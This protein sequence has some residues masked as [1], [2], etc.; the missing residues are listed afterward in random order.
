MEDEVLADIADVK[1]ILRGLGFLK[2]APAI[3]YSHTMVQNG[4]YLDAPASGCWYPRK[5]PGDQI[6]KGEL[7]GE[8]RNIF[9][10]PLCRIH[11]ETDGVVL[12]Q[13]VSLGIETGAPMIAYGELE[14][15]V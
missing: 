7:L 5:K 11:A 2:D 15:E 14:K 10:E 12:Y 13:T 6:Q 8:I 3:S 9:S 4:R 1:N